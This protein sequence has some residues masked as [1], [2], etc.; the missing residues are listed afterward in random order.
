MKGCQD[1]D[2]DDGGGGGGVTWSLCE[3]RSDQ[4]EVPAATVLESVGE[5]EE[6]GGWDTG[7]L[8]LLV[9]STPF[10]MTATSTSTLS[11]SHTSPGHWSLVNQTNTELFSSANIQSVGPPTLT[12]A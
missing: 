10:Y 7:P 1:D 5:R 12:P 9:T 8:V 2:D 3:E 11:F 6:G 4:E